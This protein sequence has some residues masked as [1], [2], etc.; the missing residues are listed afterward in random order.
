MWADSAGPPWETR[1]SWQAAN[2]SIRSLLER[3]P[4]KMQ[5]LFQTAGEIRQRLD[6]LDAIYDEL[7]PQTCPLCPEPCCARAD[8]W[9]DLRDLLF[10]HAGFLPVPLE[11]PRKPDH[12]PCWFL[13]PGG[14]RLPRKSRPWICTWYLCPAQKHRLQN[15]RPAAFIQLRTLTEEIGE[16]RKQLEKHFIRVTGAPSA[17]CKPDDTREEKAGGWA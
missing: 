4:R 9:F 8:V 17:A 11:N 16:Y 10:V 7:C 5:P 15:R 3:H 12:L 1:K 14:C 6:V 13:G 2:F